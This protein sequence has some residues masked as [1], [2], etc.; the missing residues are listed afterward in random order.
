MFAPISTALRP[1][2]MEVASPFSQSSFTR[3]RQG[4]GPKNPGLELNSGT[5]RIVVSAKHDHHWRCTGLFRNAKSTFEKCFAIQHEQLFGLA[6]AAAG[7]GGKYD[8]SD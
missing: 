5:N 8:G 2:W 7:S 1:A 6:E 3:K 4:I